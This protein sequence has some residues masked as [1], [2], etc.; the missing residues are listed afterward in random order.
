MQRK[1]TLALFGF[2]I[3][4]LVSCGLVPKG[5]SAASATSTTTATNS[6]FSNPAGVQVPGPSSS[7]FNNPYYSCSKN[8]Y[9]ST[10][11]SDSNN[12][13]S[14]SPWLTLRHADSMNLGAGACINVAPG[15]YDG[16]VVYHGGSAATSTGYVVYRCQTM[17]A[18][19][20]TGNAGQNSNSSV[21]FDTTNISATVPNTVNYVQ[22]DGFILMAKPLASQGPYGVGFVAYNCNLS[23]CNGPEVASHHIWLLNSIISG[24]DQGGVA[25]G[26]S[27]YFYMIHNT[28]Y[29]NALSQCD[30]QGSGIAINIAHDVPG[31]SPTADDQNP[32]SGFG[33]PT[34]E[35]GDGTFF[36]VVFAYNVTYNNR[37]QG[38][39]A[40]N[41]TDGNGIIFD[42]NG[43]ADGNP[44]DY[45]NPML[46]YGN[47]SYNN[48]GGGVHITA[49]YNVTIANNTSFNNY[50]NPDQ[51]GGLAEIDDNGGSN[52]DT[53]G[54]TYVNSFYNN[55]GVACTTSSP[56]LPD[57]GPSALLLGPTKG[58]DPAQ[59]NL[60]YMVT[61]SANCNPE[62]RIYNYQQPYST[63]LNKEAANPMW[64]NVTF[65]SPGSDAVQP[66]GTNFALSPGSPAIGFG[67]LKPWMPATATD[68][69]ACPSSL[70]SCP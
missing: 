35:L 36:H 51:N 33:F 24:F 59:G 18:C 9:V 42:T 52:T 27:D 22:F 31:Y 3:I 34:L 49:S 70:M 4:A 55:I 45:H 53:N 25:V 32:F 41:V 38:C 61:N 20:I 48:G 57:G 66:A 46:A 7:L 5:K 21:F 8:Y 37:I 54:V 23:T 39:G 19:T 68:A 60:T 10:A 50:I 64:V 1:I 58:S 17:D 26:A 29:S 28:S 47:V 11:G 44:T 30:A 67:V 63:L 56:S 16:F 15:T 13:S 65:N 14:A 43:G 69:G 62:V 40:G 6:S 2:G 12:G